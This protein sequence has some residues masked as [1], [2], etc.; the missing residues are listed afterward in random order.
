[1]RGRSWRLLAAG[2]FS[3]LTSPAWSA[4]VYYYQFDQSSYSVAPGGT[5]DVTVYLVENTGGGTSLLGGEGLLTGGVR[6]SYAGTNTDDRATLTSKDAISANPAFNESLDNPVKYL[7]SDFVAQ[8]S[9]A[10]NPIA[11]LSAMRADGMEEG[12]LGEQIGADLYRVALGTFR[13]TG[14]AVENDI[15]TLQASDLFDGE[16]YNV[17]FITGQMLELSPYGIG[18][19]TTTI[20]VVP[21]PPGIVALAGMAVMGLVL[22]TVHGRRRA[23]AVSTGIAC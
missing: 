5:V 11:G 2:L 19:A 6:L 9:G 1:M 10:G 3:F 22:W 4:P 17:T 14:G 13:F 12:V 7:T 16:T 23:A 8:G 20:T 15:T 21:E 18:T